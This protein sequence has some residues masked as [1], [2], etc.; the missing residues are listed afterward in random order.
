MR[1]L[2]SLGWKMHGMPFCLKVLRPHRFLRRNGYL[3]R[4]SRN[5]A[6][7]DVLAWSGFGSVGISLLQAALGVSRGGARNDGV[8]TEVARFDEWTDVLWQ[9]HQH[10]YACLAVRDSS[11]MNSLIPSSGL[12]NAKRLRVDRG[13]TPIGWAVVHHAA[14]TTDAR[15]GDLSVGL[16]SDCFGA[17]T[18]APSII[19]AA[20]DFLAKKNVDLVYSNQSHPAWVSAFERTGYLTL[21]DRRLF[22]CSPALT[23]LLEPIPSWSRGLHLTNMDGHGPHGFA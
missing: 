15:F 1:L 9:Q 21:A 4:S 8:A 2:R 23:A 10:E 5:R 11:M 6:I 16:I 3:R 19:G 20:T 12:Q 14:S 13:T 18:D 7:L 17:L 22:A